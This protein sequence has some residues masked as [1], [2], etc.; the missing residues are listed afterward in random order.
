MAASGGDSNMDTGRRVKGRHKSTGG[1]N[2]AEVPSR[3]LDMAESGD[4]IKMN[5]A[6]IELASDKQF[7]PN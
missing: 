4:K 2:S 6:R 5:M 7:D 1:V 3:V